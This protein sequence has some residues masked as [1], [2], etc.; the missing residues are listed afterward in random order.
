MIPKT[1]RKQYVRSGNQI[2]DA[3]Q[4]YLGNLIANAKRRREENQLNAYVGDTVWCKFSDTP[5][6][7]VNPGTIIRIEIDGATTVYTVLPDNST[8]YETFVNEDF[9]DLIFKEDD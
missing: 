9:G 1:L 8:D 5:K 6:G 3:S 2:A 4:K 7:E